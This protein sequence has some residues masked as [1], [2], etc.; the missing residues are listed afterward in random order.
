VITAGQRCWLVCVL[1]YLAL[2]GCGSPVTKPDSGSKPAA[3]PTPTVTITSPNYAIAGAASFNLQVVG[4]NFTSNSEVEW[5]GIPLATEFVSSQF[6]NVAIDNLKIGAA[7]SSQI[8]VHD[9][10]TGKASGEYTFY[11]LSSAAA[12]AGFAQLISIAPDGSA[13]NDDS[14]VA[15]SISS[16]GR[17]VAFQSSATNLGTWPANGRE[18]IYLRDTCI[19]AE[20]S[21]IPSTRL[22][23]ATYDGSDPNGHNY[24]SAVSDDGRFVVFESNA[25]NILPATGNCGVISCVYLRDMCTGAI[26]GCT[27][28]TTLISKDDNGTPFPAA[29]TSITPDGRYISI[30]GAITSGVVQT[31]AF[32]SCYGATRECVKG[33]QIYSLN[34][35]GQPGNENSL[36]QQLASDGRYAAFVTFSSNMQDPTA[37]ASGNFESV[38]LRDTCLGAT[39]PCTPTTLRQDV[40]SN[41]IPNNGNLAET[42]ASISGTGRYVAFSADSTTTNL[43]PENVGNHANV[44]LRDTCIAVASGCTASTVLVSKGSDGTIGNSF[45]GGQSL[46]ADGRF[47][48]FSSIA[49]NLVPFDSFPAGSRKEIYGR[50]T[51]AGAP[52][53]CSPSTVRLAVTNQ[54]ALLTL[55]NQMSSYPVISGDGHYVVFLSNASNFIPSANVQHTM[56]Y[57]AKT[58]F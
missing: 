52:A 32:D 2:S 54:P 35:A 9:T 12:T 11:I 19:G 44:Y 13:A 30:S 7:G 37:P 27:P 48:V 56:V 36:G 49:T 33:L 28:V 26:S 3:P 15:A 43:V 46:S 53:G 41:E 10:A 45:S 42:T 38:Q 23:S 58:G 47:V 55:A 17:F 51:C 16:T 29:Y 21:C 4:T 24:S 1:M 20:A 34:V 25:S 22:V 31:V 6:L 8:A 57:L 5:N 50:D 40:S 18:Q 39:S 14:A